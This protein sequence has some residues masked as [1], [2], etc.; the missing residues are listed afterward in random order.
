M[1]GPRL[2]SSA[3]DVPCPACG[4]AIRTTYGQVIDE[5]TVVCPLGH[6]VRLVDNGDS[7]RRL[8]RS[9]TD[10]NRQL[11]RIGRRR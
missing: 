7:V 6:S 1:R 5:A 4:S 2:R 10:L 8:D 9:L 3:L 11:R